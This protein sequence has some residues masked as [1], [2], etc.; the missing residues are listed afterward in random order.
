M[1]AA[2]GA[3]C[4]RDAANPALEARLPLPCDS[5]GALLDSIRLSQIA[6]SEPTRPPGG[7]V[8]GVVVPPAKTSE[9]H[10]V[11][12]YHADRLIAEQCAEVMKKRMV[13]LFEP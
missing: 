4:L 6:T 7:K 12:A 9:G 8:R 13:G 2:P 11:T 10:D 3:F 5:A 1:V